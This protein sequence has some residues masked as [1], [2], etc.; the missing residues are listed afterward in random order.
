MTDDSRRQLRAAVE[1]LLDRAYPPG[2]AI[3][4][5]GRCKRPDNCLAHSILEVWGIEHSDSVCADV[6]AIVRRWLL[7]RR[8]PV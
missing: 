1:A 5:E 3:T 7:S 6:S 8:V 2:A 4:H